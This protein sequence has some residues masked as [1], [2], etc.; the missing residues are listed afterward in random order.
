MGQLDQAALDLY[1]ASWTD[2]IALTSGHLSKDRKYLV[3]DDLSTADIQLAGLLFAS[4]YNDDLRG[5]AEYSDKI[6]ALIKANP[7][8]HAYVER[9][10]V[11]FADYRANRI[12]APA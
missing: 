5:G 9:L 1:V 3:T 2:I 8:Y 11:D 10:L 4:V 7:E 6:K 12:H